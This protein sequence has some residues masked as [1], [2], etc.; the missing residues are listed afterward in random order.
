M[1]YKDINCLLYI[2]LKEIVYHVSMVTIVYISY[3][4]SIICKPIL[5]TPSMYCIFEYSHFFSQKEIIYTYLWA[6]VRVLW[7]LKVVK[8]TLLFPWKQQFWGYFPIMFWLFL[9]T[10]DPVNSGLV[11]VCINLSARIYRAS[12]KMP[13]F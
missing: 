8:C 2:E 6:V 12:P 5:Q 1:R 9:I 11:S 10:E 4:D 13:H 7:S 3:L